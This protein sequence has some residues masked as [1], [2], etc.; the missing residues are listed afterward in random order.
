MPT[1]QAEWMS[2]P[3]ITPHI[4]DSDPDNDE[5]EANFSDNEV[6]WFNVKMNF[7]MSKEEQID[8]KRCFDEQVRLGVIEKDGRPV[9]MP[10]PPKKVVIPN[11]P[12]NVLNSPFANKI[13]GQVANSNKRKLILTRKSR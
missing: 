4:D 12:S 10:A 3:F 11:R 1:I 5:V 2:S 13:A 9:G 6:A 7:V 8:E